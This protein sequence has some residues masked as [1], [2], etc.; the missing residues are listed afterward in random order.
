MTNLAVL[1]ATFIALVFAGYMLTR[2]LISYAHRKQLLDVANHR[3]SHTL[4]TP[5]IGGLGFVVLILLLMPLYNLLYLPADAIG[6]FCF[7]WLPCFIVATTG[8]LD[9]IRGLSRR[10]RFSLYFLSA[11]L[12][13]GNLKMLAEIWLP[14]AVIIGLLAA[15][16]ISWLINLFNFMDGIDGIAGSEAVFLLGALAWLYGAQQSN[17]IAGVILL[18]AAPVTGFLI[19]NWQPARIFMG[20]IGSTFLGCF[21]G[22]ILLYA[23]DKS[24]I[25]L[26]SA[27]ILTAGFWVDA[28]WTLAYRL[29]SGQRW[30][31]AH[32]SHTYQILA[33]QFNSHQRVTLGL[34]AINLAWLFPLALLANQSPQYALLITTIS[35]LPLIGLC[36]IIG[37][38]KA[39]SN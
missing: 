10:L 8:L 27:A 30:Y 3:S 34:T 9:D 12:A 24:Y 20:D 7:V 37:A 38:G 28:T 36:F 21:V 16:A 5:R 14:L 23:I 13:L 39:S 2:W 26:C 19:S 18:A 11:L 25:S 32:R 15:L 33:R 22:C 6:L 4:A 1:P 35:L 29:F 17:P 31:Q